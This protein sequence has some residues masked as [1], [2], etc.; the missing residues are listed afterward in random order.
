MQH[1]GD[2]YHSDLLRG[3]NPSESR[4]QSMNTNISIGS[5]GS[6]QHKTLGVY[7]G[8]SNRSET[9]NTSSLQPALLPLVAPDLL[10]CAKPVLRD[11]WEYNKRI[12]NCILEESQAVGELV[13]YCSLQQM[14][15]HL[16]FVS[17]VCSS[18]FCF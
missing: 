1:D 4:T 13:M 18:I 16:V 15:S 6:G 12:S 3:R 14:A 11:S 9:I 7:T 8:Q 2:N 10:T 17:F 5:I